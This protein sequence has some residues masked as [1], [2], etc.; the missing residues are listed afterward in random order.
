MSTDNKDMHI[1]VIDSHSG[2]GD[3]LPQQLW[4]NALLHGQEPA[5]REKHLGI[6]QEVNWSGYLGH[7]RRFTLGLVEMG[8]K[9]G[10]TVAIQAENCQEWL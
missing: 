6:W 3:T 4:N 5:I 9:R 10:E 8:L 1:P 7:V 2:R